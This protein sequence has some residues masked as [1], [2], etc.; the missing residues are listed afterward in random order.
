[1]LNNSQQQLTEGVA[2]NSTDALLDTYVN[3]YLYVFFYSEYVYLNLY[4][5]IIFLL[6]MYVCTPELMEIGN[7]KTFVS[8]FNKALL[9]FLI[10]FIVL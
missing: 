3:A 8:A 6:H 1:M 9:F 2:F 5:F 4:L 10:D 7:L